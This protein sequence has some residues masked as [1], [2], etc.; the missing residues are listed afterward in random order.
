LEEAVKKIGRKR[1]NNAKEKKVA[2]S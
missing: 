2:N 1:P